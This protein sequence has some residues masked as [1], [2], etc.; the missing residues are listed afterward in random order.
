MLKSPHREGP[1]YIPC[2]LLYT[3]VPCL[4]TRC[5]EFLTSLA[6]ADPVLP[7]YG[8]WLTV[9]MDVRS[10]RYVS[11]LANCERMTVMLLNNPFILTY[12]TQCG[13]TE[14]NNCCN[15]LN[16]MYLSEIRSPNFCTNQFYI[17]FFRWFFC[18]CDFLPK[19]R[20]LKSKRKL[21]LF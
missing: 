16:E 13:A 1:L 6:C 7:N 11:Y 15:I 3:I 5:S 20:D 18:N 9:F 10:A 8:H 19:K 12:T 2:S 4:L 14:L 17:L 21:R